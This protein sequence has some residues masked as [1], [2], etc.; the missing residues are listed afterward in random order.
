MIVL[1]ASG[2]GNGLQPGGVGS[3]QFATGSDVSTGFTTA[4]Q[5]FFFDADPTDKALW[6]DADGSGSAFTPVEI[7]TVGVS[8][9]LNQHD[10]VII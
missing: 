3:Q 5:R 10:L 7:V 4:S 6:Y 2:F 9:T 1:S 8:V